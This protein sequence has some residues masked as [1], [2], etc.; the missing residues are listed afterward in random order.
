MLVGEIAMLAANAGTATGKKQ[1]PI[2]TTKSCT[3]QEE[4]GNLCMHRF[5]GRSREA[6]RSEKGIE[7]LRGLQTIPVDTGVLMIR[8]F[9]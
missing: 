5:C 6:A 4:W 2:K 9:K 7:I 3:A 8:S 1:R